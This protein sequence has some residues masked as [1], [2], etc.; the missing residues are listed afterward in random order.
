MFENDKGE[1]S[2]IKDYF[3]VRKRRRSKRTLLPGLFVF[4]R[5]D[6]ATLGELRSGNPALRRVLIYLTRTNSTFHSRQHREAGC[7]R[8]G[9]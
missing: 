8:N 3:Q 2:S 6:V 9:R 7:R 4:G 1:Q 5:G